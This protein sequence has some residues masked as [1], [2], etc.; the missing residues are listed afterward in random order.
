MLTRRTLLGYS[1]GASFVSLGGAIPWLFARAAEQSAKAD[2]NDHALVVIELGGGNDG[3]NTVIPYHEPLYYKNRRTLGIPEKKVLRLG[4]QLGLHPKMGAMA[5][6]FGDGHVAIVQGV[7]Y[8]KPDRSHFRSMEIWHTASVEER[9]PTF[10]WLGRY[11]DATTKNST[12]QTLAALA[13]NDQLPQAFHAESCVVPVVSKLEALPPDDDDEHAGASLLRTLSTATI[14]SPSPVPFLRRQAASFYRT[15]DTLKAASAAY[16][17]KADYPDGDLAAQ[18]RHA[19]QILSAGIGT[20][21][22]FV[23]QG[24]YDTHANQVDEHATLLD[25]LSTSLSAFLKDA[26]A[27]GFADRVVVLVFSEFGRR[28]DENASKGTDHGAASCSFLCG[29]KVKGGLVGAY[30]SLASLGEG[31]LVYSTDFRSVYASILENWLRCPSEPV[32]GAKFPTLP[33]F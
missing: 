2:A 26:K 10:G 4:D 7:G 13:L 15:A 11:L 22:L 14:R 6:L 16:K 23:S 30:P 17:P 29:H 3:L 31:D 12:P 19:A 21:V 33:L 8:P 20:R 1:A 28:V 5:E 25:Q 9:Q 24:G 32:L 27:Q 18:L